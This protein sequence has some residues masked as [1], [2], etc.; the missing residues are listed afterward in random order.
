MIEM[1]HGDALEL[2]N[3][4]EHKIDLLVSDPPYTFGGDGDEHALSAVVAVVLREAALKLRPA[5]WAVVFAAASW[6]STFY[7][8]EALRGVCEPRRI[9]TWV[10]PRAHTRV[11]TSGWRWASVNAVVLQRRAGHHSRAR[12]GGD[13]DEL[14]YVSAPPARDGRRAQLPLD[15]AEWA[16]APF[17]V[18]GGVMLDPF[19]GSGALPVAAARHGMHAYGFDQ[20]AA[21]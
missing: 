18:A 2:V 21:R 9:G 12:R 10:K 14:D 5:A 8:V 20:K 11:S 6:R 17:A 4:F 7:M 16:V 1:R 3:D 13:V 15:V 19:A